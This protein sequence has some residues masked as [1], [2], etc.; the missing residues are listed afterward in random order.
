MYPTRNDIPQGKRVKIVKLLNDR[1]ADC[2]VL[3]THMKQ[4]HWNVRGPHF[5]GLHELFDRVNNGVVEYIDLIAER[6]AQLGGVMIGT[7]EVVSKQSEIPDYPLDISTG[8]EHVKAVSIALAAF[9]ALARAAIDQCNELDDAD[10]ADIFTEVSRGID[11][12]LWFVE[13]HAQAD[14]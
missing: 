7:A 4:A 12:W 8:P 14:R 6:G 9:G 2:I 3:Q 5:I 10:A 1:L 11:Q 13:A